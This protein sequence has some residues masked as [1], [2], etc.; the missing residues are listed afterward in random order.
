MRDTGGLV[1]KGLANNWGGSGQTGGRSFGRRNNRLTS[2]SQETKTQT[3]LSST[4]G[5]QTEAQRCTHEHTQYDSGE[6]VVIVTPAAA[7]KDLSLSLS[8]SLWAQET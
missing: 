2:R 3:P 1:V 6:G 8:L 4:I 7:A 5:R